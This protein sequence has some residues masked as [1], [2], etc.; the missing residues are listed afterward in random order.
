MWFCFFVCL[1]VFFWGL[2]KSVQSLS[3]KLKCINYLDCHTVF[4][5]L[6]KYF[7]GKLFSFAL[8]SSFHLWGFPY[9]G[10]TD[11]YESRI[12]KVVGRGPINWNLRLNDWIIVL[13]KEMIKDYETD[14]AFLFWGEDV[15]KCSNIKPE[16]SNIII[17]AAQLSSDY[18]YRWELLIIPKVAP[19]NLVFYFLS[20]ERWPPVGISPFIPTPPEQEQAGDIPALLLVE[21]IILAVS[22]KDVLCT[23]ANAFSS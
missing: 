5:V 1:F 23:K 20:C 22:S 14:G 15:A 18:W 11:L 10:D 12:P 3:Y 6:S 19:I 9:V 4:F 21:D 13:M 8:C 2:S 7:H 16:W 17:R